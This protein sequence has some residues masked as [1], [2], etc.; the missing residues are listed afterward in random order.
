MPGRLAFGVELRRRRQLAHLSLTKFGEL[1]HYSKGHL[2]KIESGGKTVHPVLARQCDAVLN[3]GG[4]LAALAM[5]AANLDTPTEPPETTG[6]D[7][8]SWSMS[9]D[10]DGTVR[11]APGAGPD[12]RAAFGMNLAATRHPV[13]PDTMLAVFGARYVQVRSLGQLV[14]AAF[15]LPMLIAE[16]HTLRAIASSAPAESSADLWLLAARFAEYV[17][18]MSQESGNDQ[19]AMFWTRMAVRM[20]AHAGDESLRPY[21]LFRRA[22]MTMYADDPHQTIGLAQQAQADTAATARVRGLAAQ[23]EAQGYALLGDHDACLRALDRSAVLLDEAGQAPGVAPVLG[24]WTTPDATAMARGWCL[25]DL[26]RPAEAAAL[27]ESGIAGFADG[28]SRS[29]AR[30]AVRTALAQATADEMDRACEIVE[31]LADDLRQIDSATI[32]H[33]V[34]LLNREFRR[35]AGQQP[36]VRELLPVL[37]DLLR[38]PAVD[39]GWPED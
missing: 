12:V 19:H 29:R 30:F 31:W 26:G 23:R 2:S 34:R 13:D 27:L 3:A 7:T 4:E 25:F 20:A 11:V 21:A 28:A 6:P 35:R 24:I 15:T 32:R 38:G 17:G 14:S 16:T 39:P 5:D 18:W 8:G 36:R 37:A 22:D 9:L 33:D 1:V 10:S